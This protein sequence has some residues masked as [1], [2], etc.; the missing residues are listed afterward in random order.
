MS[1]PGPTA[2]PSDA[3]TPV[4]GR[5]L[6]VA[7]RALQHLMS[8][9]RESWPMLA[10]DSKH[11]TSK[12]TEA[13]LECPHP[14][15]QRRRGGNR[16]GKYEHCGKCGLRL[17]FVTAAAAAAATTPAPSSRSSGLTE[18]QRL[19]GSP[20]LPSAKSKAKA[21]T[22][23]A[24]T[25]TPE[26]GSSDLTSA[27]LRMADS[28]RVQTES[29]TQG[30]QAMLQQQAALMQQQNQI[31]GT[32]LQSLDRLQQTIMVLAAP[33]P[34]STPA[35]PPPRMEPPT[36]AFHAETVQIPVVD[37]TKDDEMGEWTTAAVDLTEDPAL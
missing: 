1:S 37:L 27:M 22:T 16:Y 2:S 17:K 18:A 15:G 36:E 10:Q 6:R 29:L 12:I 4:I 19:S 11:K 9:R 33:T 35:L 7:W 20:G 5:W 3:L 24:S 34:E 28:Q 31:T 26:A 21:Q 8:V 32:M 23:P 14:R 25:A 30:M 13:Q